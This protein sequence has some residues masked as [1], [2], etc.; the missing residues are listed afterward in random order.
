MKHKTSLS[1]FES[2]KKSYKK[3]QNLFEMNSYNVQFVHGN[4]K[5]RFAI[6]RFKAQAHVVTV[7][8]SKDWWERTPNEKELDKCALHEACHLLIFKL[9]N[10]TESRFLTE[11]EFIELDEEITIKLEN[12][13]NKII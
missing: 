5:D 2:F 13:F 9:S 11:S 3:Y 10:A 6:S 12:I 1:N 7:G 8:L 4:F